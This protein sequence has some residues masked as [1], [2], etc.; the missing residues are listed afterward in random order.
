M[1]D[2]A[3]QS[4]L[5]HCWLPLVGG[6]LLTVA[7]LRRGSWPGFAI[8][9]AGGYLIYRS[10]FSSEHSAS[11][12]S[13]CKTLNTLYRRWLDRYGA[14]VNAGTFDQVSQAAK[15]GRHPAGTY[16]D[17][18]VAEASDDSFPCSDPPAWAM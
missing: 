5:L 14:G 7:G 4:E 9:L 3:P 13:S 12:E 6:G 10:V 15:E 2:Q 8:A 16:I 11:R 1:R 17:D 18:L